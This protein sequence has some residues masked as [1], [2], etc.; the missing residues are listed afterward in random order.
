MAEKC[1]YCGTEAFVVVDVNYDSDGSM[2]FEWECL[3]C[4]ES[5]SH[6]SF[7]GRRDDPSDEMYIHD[8]AER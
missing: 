2:N 5:Y 4:G 8:D 6:N 3:E 1:P 7:D